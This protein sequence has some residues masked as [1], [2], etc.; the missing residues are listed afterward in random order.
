L[1][2]L[3]CPVQIEGTGYQ[4]NGGR[5]SF[6][7][8]PGEAVLLNFPWES[9]CAGHKGGSKM[10]GNCEAGLKNYWGKPSMRYMR[11][12]YLEELV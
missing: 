8:W 12:Q 3:K 1:G 5:A 10:Y 11:P 9:C 6:R 4:K 2:S 7:L